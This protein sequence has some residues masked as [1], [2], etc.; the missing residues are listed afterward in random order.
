MGNVQRV[1]HTASIEMIVG[2]TVLSGT[3][4]ASEGSITGSLTGTL[5]GTSSF[6]TDAQLAQQATQ[7]ISASFGTITGSF[8]GSDSA[9]TSFFGSASYAQEAA[10]AQE[11]TSSISASFA[12]GG[13]VVATVGPFSVQINSTLGSF[14]N[15]TGIEDVVDELGGGLSRMKLSLDN[16]NEFRITTAIDTQDEKG[17]QPKM[18]GEFSLDEITWNSFSPE[19]FAYL[20]QSAI[21]ADSGYKALVSE[22][23]TDVFLRVS[24]F[25]GPSSGPGA[26]AKVGLIAMYFR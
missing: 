9:S 26:S 1:L 3:I 12:S 10:F 5:E 4:D 23:K 14:A 15:L 7:S 6:A 8:L 25:D 24:T 16:Y 22:S 17:A 2:T 11:A 21:T 13:I 20:T 19:A 18:I